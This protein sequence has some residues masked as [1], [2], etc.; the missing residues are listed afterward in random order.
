MTQSSPNTRLIRRGVSKPSSWT[1]YLVAAISSAT[2]L[3]APLAQAAVTAVSFGFGSDFNISDG[4][5]YWSVGSFGVI[6]GTVNSI[7]VQLGGGTGQV[8]QNQSFDVNNGYPVFFN[9]GDVIGS[10][11]GPKYTA[12][13]KAEH[14]TLNFTTD[15]T[16]KL[17]GFVTNTNHFGWANVSYDVSA[18]NLHINSAYVESVAG[19]SITAGNVG[20]VPEPSRALLALAGLGV[21]ALRRRRKQAV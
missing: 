8:F 11:T 18:S 10:S 21:V 4:S 13:F 19:N 9:Y 5:N 16:N 20:V 14:A 15:Q 12:F 2:I 1:G 17:I 3:A 6:E 7:R